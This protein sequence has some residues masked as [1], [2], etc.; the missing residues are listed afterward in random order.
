MFRY[1]PP[2]EEGE[3]EEPTQ[4]EP[5]VPSEGPWLRAELD[6]WCEPTLRTELHNDM[7]HQV[8]DIPGSYLGQVP[9]YGHLLPG[10]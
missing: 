2:E 6:D 3:E 10:A 4:E 1:P 9:R 8:F 5:T 7:M